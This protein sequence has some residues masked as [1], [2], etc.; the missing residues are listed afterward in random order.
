MYETIYCQDFDNI[1]SLTI[2]ASK[3]RAVNLLAQ[4]LE[5]VFIKYKKAISIP[6]SKYTYLGMGDVG[7][8]DRDSQDPIFTREL[9]FHFITTEVLKMEEEQIK[10]INLTI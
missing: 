9:S 7:F 10:K 6:A 1:I 8:L 5:S 4:I 2:F 3:A